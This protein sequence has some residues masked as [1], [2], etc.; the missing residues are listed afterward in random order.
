MITYQNRHPLSQDNYSKPMKLSAYS[1]TAHTHPHTST[2][3]HYNLAEQL[4]A[5]TSQYSSSLSPL[6][7]ICMQ[8]SDLSESLHTE[9]SNQ[10]KKYPTQ[11]GYITE[12]Y[13]S[14]KHQP[15]PQA[16]NRKAAHMLDNILNIVKNTVFQRVEVS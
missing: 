14:Q 7:S 10:Q 12:N 1:S 6:I 11:N 16:S 9:Q 2:I 8:Q 4:S 3:A 5:S 15:E 13:A